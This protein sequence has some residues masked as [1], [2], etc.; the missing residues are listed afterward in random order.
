MPGVI[1]P[2]MTAVVATTVINDVLL[3]LIDKVNHTGKNFL[4]I[5]THNA[6]INRAVNVYMLT[7][8][9]LVSEIK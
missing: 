2:C 7:V 6:R 9:F 5:H 3:H 8:Q 1:P 4:F